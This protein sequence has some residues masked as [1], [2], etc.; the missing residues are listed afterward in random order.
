MGNVHFS[1]RNRDIPSYALNSPRENVF[2]TN[3]IRFHIDG[4]YLT[5]FSD[6]GIDRFIEKNFNDKTGFLGGLG[7]GWGGKDLEFKEVKAFIQA[8]AANA[9]NIKGMT[10]DLTDPQLGLFDDDD[11]KVEDIKH[12]FSM[13]YKPVQGTSAEEVSFVDATKLQYDIRAAKSD[14]TR[15]ETTYKT[16]QSSH[17]ELQKDLQSA[18]KDR[19]KIADRIG[20]NAMQRLAEIDGKLQGFDTRIADLNKDMQDARMRLSQDHISPAEKRELKLMMRGMEMELKEIKADKSKVEKQLTKNHGFWS[21]LGGGSNLEDL[22]KANKAVEQARK[23]VEDNRPTYEAARNRWQDA[24]K[25]REAVERGESLADYDKRIAAAKAPKAEA[26]ADKPADTPAAVS[27]D[28]PADNSA[29]PQGATQPAVTSGGLTR[30]EAD[31]QQILSLPANKQLEALAKV[32][33]ED[34]QAFLKFADE[35]LLAGK[36]ENPL[37]LDA[38]NHKSFA[39]AQAPLGAL[40]LNA[41]LSWGEDAQKSYFDRAGDAGAQEI[42]AQIEAKI[43]D[44]QL[45]NQAEALRAR[46]AARPKPAVE[47]IKPPAENLPA[48]IQAAVKPATPPVSTADAQTGDGPGPVSDAGAKPPVAPGVQPAGTLNAQGFQALSADQKLARFGDLPPADQDLVF[49]GMT[50]IDKGAILMQLASQ[51]IN[52]HA[53]RE[54]LSALMRPDEK[55]ALVN[56]LDAIRKDTA[57]VPY[58]HTTELSMLL[59]MF[60]K[61]GVSPTAAPGTQ[62]A[63]E[64]KPEVKQADQTPV[65]KPAQKPAKKPAQKPAVKPAA[66]QKPAVKPAAKPEAPSQ[67]DIEWALDL[68]RKIEKEGHKPTQAEID[69]YTDIERRAAAAD[70]AATSMSEVQEKAATQPSVDDKVKALREM[71]PI[72]RMQAF[73]SLT[74]EGK[75]DVFNKL[76]LPIQTELLLSTA[77]PVPNDPDRKGLIAGLNAQTKQALSQKYVE[78]LPAAKAMDVELGAAM[79]K[80]ISELGGPPKQSQAATSTPAIETQAKPTAQPQPQAAPVTETPG[81]PQTARLDMSQQ[82][83]QLKGILGDRSYFGYGSVNNQQGMSQLVEQIWGMGTDANRQAMA[84]LLVDNKQAQLLAQV[85]SNVNVTPEEAVKTLSA[86]DFPIK[87]FMNDVD[88]S[89]SFLML[90]TLGKAAV[91]NDATGK[92]AAA[93]ISETVTAYQ[94]GMDREKP[95]TRFKQA[96]QQDQFWDKLP[97]DL[98]TKI[99]KMFSTWWN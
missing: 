96:A 5:D 52:D 95:F 3:N 86:G 9:E 56:Q 43:F 73:A 42:M 35:Y 66:E 32:A 51:N 59:G 58:P 17:R 18:I 6:K 97:K 34:R 74:L 33:P 76:S 4:K 13:D 25:R 84:K 63:P 90:H 88:D 81:Q 93:L 87:R 49:S 65:Q 80:L 99:D 61:Q 82:I 47:E 19:D 77:Y 15:T 30:P 64:V 68:A 39:D 37:G 45:A 48:D 70:E 8:A 98:Q 22:R 67:A 36:P 53:T 89:K 91:N 72:G 79:E 54:R 11:I 46:L 83:G 27:G 24:V 92:R 12:S 31:L 16:A 21:F 26:P 23:A 14:E 94:S 62:T 78:G 44:Q 71:E 38:A 60:A 55:Q 7:L 2:E 40:R 20:D 50:F 69:R 85:L 28:K 1:G 10:F 57:G 41:L 75:K 29:A